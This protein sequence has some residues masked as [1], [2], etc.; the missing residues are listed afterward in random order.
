MKASCSLAEQDLA[1]SAHVLSRLGGALVGTS[2][3]TD[4]GLA[5]VQD[6]LGEVTLAFLS[7]LG[8]QVGAAP[9]S[10]PVGL[11]TT[12]TSLISERVKVLV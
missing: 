4:H 11:C 8:S 6:L 7:G 1:A 9:L 2:L 12:K 3:E 5:G 10:V